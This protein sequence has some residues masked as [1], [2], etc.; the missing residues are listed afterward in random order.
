MDKTSIFI[1][2]LSRF[3]NEEDISI[4]FTA[5]G[6][7]NEVKIIRN[8]RTLISLGYGFALL[9]NQENAANIIKCLN[10]VMLKG[11]Q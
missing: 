11:M 5:Y 3:C 9:D 2:D 4:L 6:K 8:P 10:G 1:G 7:T